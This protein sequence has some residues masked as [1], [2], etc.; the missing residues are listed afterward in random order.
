M[1][2]SLLSPLHRRLQCLIEIP[3]DIFYVFDTDREADQVGSD[4]ASKASLF[5]ELLVSSAGRMN[6]Q[7][8]RVP[9]PAATLVFSVF[10]CGFVHR[11]VI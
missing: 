11:S 8:A 10:C 4:A 1:F 6:E 7:A 9:R 2:F 5:R 3:Q